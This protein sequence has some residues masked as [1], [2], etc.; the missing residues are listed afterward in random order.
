MYRIGFYIKKDLVLNVSSVGV[1][2]FW[3]RRG[4]CICGLRG[5]FGYCCLEFF[6]F[7]SIIF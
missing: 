5:G 6:I 4:Y 7:L 3:I 1:E 2:M